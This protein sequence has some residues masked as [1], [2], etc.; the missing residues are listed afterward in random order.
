[1]L[2]MDRIYQ[3]ILHELERDGRI[4]NT[5]LAEKVGLSAS[6][7]LRRV[8]EMEKA[9]VIQGYRAVL[10][11]E[12]MGRGFVA[13]VTV[14]LE[15]HSKAAQEAFEKTVETFPEVRECHNVTGISEYLLRVET[16]NLP[17]YKEFHTE[18]LGTAPGVR[19][20]MTHVVMDT[21]KDLRT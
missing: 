5:Q 8:Q 17:A 19:K 1:M 9:G 13:Y 2:K 20:L 3:Q 15:E 16:A 21:P 18:R 10:N 12:A 7:C 11:P 6:A 4:P 14:G